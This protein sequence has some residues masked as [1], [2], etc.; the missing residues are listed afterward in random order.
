MSNF[1][2]PILRY[3]APRYSTDKVRIEAIEKGLQDYSFQL[4]K[5]LYYTYTVSTGTLGAGAEFA[6]TAFDHT[7]KRIPFVSIVTSNAK[8]VPFV[9]ATST[10]ITV[11]AT[12]AD[13]GNQSADINLYYW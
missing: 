13:T 11:C 8:I 12:N 7:L 10:Q 6:D 4:Q 9:K 3:F 2:G 5:H 1:L